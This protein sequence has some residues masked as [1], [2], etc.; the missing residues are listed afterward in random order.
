LSALLRQKGIRAQ[1]VDGA[2]DFNAAGYMLALFPM[3][4]RVLHGLG[5]FDAFLARSEPM[6]T[7]TMR[8]GHG[9]AMQTFD[10]AGALGRFGVTRQLARA[11]LLQ[12]LRD[13]APDTPLEMGVRVSARR[14]TPCRRTT[15]TCSSGTSRTVAHRIGPMAA[16]R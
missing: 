5:A 8:N 14:S 13:C 7:Y 12:I 2:A 1:L 10:I 4:N 16:S 9:E 3:G 15:G 6:D 11:D